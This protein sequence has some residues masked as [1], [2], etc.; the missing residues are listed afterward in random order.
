MFCN[1]DLTRRRQVGPG[2]SQQKGN[3]SSH[4]TRF[5][6][7]PQ[8]LNSPRSQ[9]LSSVLH[10]KDTVSQSVKQCGHGRRCYQFDRLHWQ[11]HCQCWN[12]LLHAR[13][14]VAIYML[15][16]LRS[17]M[18]VGQRHLQRTRAVAMRAVCHSCS[19]ATLATLEVG[20]SP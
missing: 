10:K 5:R 13:T 14:F 20:H 11:R 16:A 7:R 9:P 12:F 15:W 4:C 1:K 3:A 6:R 19:A 2:A 8:R 17:S 18:V